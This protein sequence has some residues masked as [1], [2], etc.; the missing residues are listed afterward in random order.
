MALS[1]VAGFWVARPWVVRFSMRYLPPRGAEFLIISQ[2]VRV[3]ADYRRES[4]TT[5]PVTDRFNSVMTGT[6]GLPGQDN[7]GRKKKKSFLFKNKAEKL[8][9]YVESK[10]E[11][12]I[13]NKNFA[14]KVVLPTLC[15]G[16]ELLTF[17]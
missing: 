4:A 14:R 17:L 7:A 16:G 9:L 8:V 13:K 6:V 12:R 1:W 2:V 11:K 15:G 5:S 10:R 3:C